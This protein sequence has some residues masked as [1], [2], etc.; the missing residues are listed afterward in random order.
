MAL[1]T[2]CANRYRF[3]GFFRTEANIIA[4]QVFFALAIGVLMWL[5][6]S[7]FY[8]DISETVRAGIK[9]SGAGKAAA[10]TG[11]E[12]VAQIEDIRTRTLYLLAALL[13]GVTALF[14]Y[15]IARVT[16]VPARNSLA[17]QKQFIGN[18]AHELRT[19]L[20]I[21]KTNVEV[22]MLDEE[23]DPKIEKILR[24]NIEELD[25][26]SEIINN[27]LSFSAFVRP[28]R[29][30]FSN[31]DLGKVVDTVTGK[32]ARLAERKQIELVVRKSEFRTVRGNP[33]ALEQIVMNILKNAI[34]YTGPAGT[35]KATVVPT[36]RDFIDLVVEDSGVGIARKDLFRIFE[37][38]YRTEHARTR[39]YGGSGLGLAIVNELV[40]THHGKIIIRS[41][42]GKGTTVI[43]S[44]PC[45]KT[46]AELREDASRAADEIAVD[47]SKKIG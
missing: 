1:V 27:L 10:E 40:K 11:E 32:L 31:V 7:Y 33:T 26:I 42:P 28:E 14:G 2:D 46:E 24:S 45:G 4:L 23:I 20:S 21:I 19:P 29:M 8:T 15:I 3:D 38:F 6:F 16:L 37:P 44:F 12:I 34:I 22:A 18:I 5:G 35:I 17:A 43:A 25:R 39:R 41:A 9:E 30:E 47:F 13:S 36:Y